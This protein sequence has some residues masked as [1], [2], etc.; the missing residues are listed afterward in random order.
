MICHLHKIVDTKLL[1][2]KDWGKTMNIQR[3][4]LFNH[5]LRIFKRGPLTHILS[6]V[7]LVIEA[8]W[9]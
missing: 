5:A 9:A 8:R 6:A 4:L 7:S 1:N 3:L 2:A